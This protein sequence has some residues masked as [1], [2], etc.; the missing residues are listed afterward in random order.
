MSVEQACDSCRKRKL[1]CSKSLPKCLKCLQHNWC[2]NYSPKT[3]RLPLTRVHLTSVENKLKDLKVILSWLLPLNNVNNLTSANY[4]TV[5]A[6][7]KTLI[8]L[9]LPQIPLDDGLSEPEDDTDSSYND[10]DDKRFHKILRQVSQ[11]GK[12]WKNGSYTTSYE[13]K[14]LESVCPKDDSKREKSR[15]SGFNGYKVKLFKDSD[16]KRNFDEQFNGTKQ[17]DGSKLFHRHSL[18]ECREHE[19]QDLDYSSYPEHFQDP[20]DSNYD[21]RNY[22]FTFEPS[23]NTTTTSNSPI[24]KSQTI[25]SPIRNLINRNQNPPIRSQMNSA[26][27]NSPLSPIIIP[28]SKIKSE[29]VNFSLDGYNDNKAKQDFKIKQ[30]ISDLNEDK[31]RQEII[32]DFNLN[33]IQ[34]RPF[35]FIT[36]NVFKYDYKVD[37]VNEIMGTNLTSPSSLLSLGNYELSEEED[38]LQPMKKYK[39]EEK[40][41][42]MDYGYMFETNL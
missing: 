3:I 16:Y 39:I 24:L 19:S 32:E 35:K 17:F 7:V 6:Q 30:E 15:D 40:K 27:Q 4:K 8:D 21:A 5:L 37:G 31:M 29:F 10:D 25:N 12:Q 20:Y 22:D 34:T 1:K 11:D 41:E 38:F 28:N 14:T 26:E 23:T 13:N 2:C 18:D 9:N 36:P 42:E 33:N